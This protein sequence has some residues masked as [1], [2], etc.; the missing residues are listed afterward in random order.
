MV[1]FISRI[2]LVAVTI[3]Y[4]S[5]AQTIVDTFTPFQ[6]FNGVVQQV[7][8]RYFMLDDNDAPTPREFTA[9]FTVGVD[10]YSQLTIP[11]STL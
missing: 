2:V 7:F 11:S 6:P 1:K 8:L 4:Y 5:L 10:D 3:V 9:G